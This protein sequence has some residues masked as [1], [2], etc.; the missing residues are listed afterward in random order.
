MFAAAMHVFTGRL[1]E[2][3]HQLYAPAEGF[4][5]FD[6]VFFHGLQPVGGYKDAWKSTWVSKV[7]SQDGKGSTACLWPQEWLPKDLPPAARILSVSYDSCAG[8]RFG[9]Q[10]NM[11]MQQIGEYLVQQLISD[12]SVRLGAR[13]VVL[14]G[15]S[16]GGIVLKQLFIEAA[17]QAAYSTN[18]SPRCADFVTNVAG[19]FF[20][21][22][23]HGGSGLAGL[24]QTA[25][26]V[27]GGDAPLLQ[28]LKVLGKEAARLNMEFANRLRNR[29]RLDFVAVYETKP[30][31]VRS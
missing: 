4:P 17:K 11:D 7:E 19:V 24:A 18:Q 15:H 26:S 12:P 20:Y 23:P 30:T 27:L 8:K 22:T 5:A 21:S 13:P 1:N 3:V 6:V 31:K 9:T 10:G 25:F 16:L 2:C 29:P 14:V 28:Y